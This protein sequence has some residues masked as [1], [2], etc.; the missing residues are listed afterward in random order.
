MYIYIRKHQ[1]S[2]NTVL[3]GLQFRYCELW[4]EAKK[5]HLR[6]YYILME[7]NRNDKDCIVDCTDFL[8]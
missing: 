1:Q 6:L 5:H 4:I 7:L 8:N 2:L 3:A